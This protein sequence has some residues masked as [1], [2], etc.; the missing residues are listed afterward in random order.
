MPVAKKIAQALGADNYN[1]LQNNGRLAHQVVDHVCWHEWFR[2]LGNTIVYYSS[3]HKLTTTGS[4]PCNT[5]TRRRAGSRDK[6]AS[7]EDRH[8]RVEVTACRP[9]KQDVKVGR[10]KKCWL[11]E[12]GFT[13]QSRN[14]TVPPTPC[15]P[16][17]GCLSRLLTIRIRQIPGTILKNLMVPQNRPRQI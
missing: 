11:R 15:C 8:G 17:S 2:R 5:K 6:L 12:P 10:L 1:V 3:Q 13:V 4:L 16:Y 7:T 14:G 9:K